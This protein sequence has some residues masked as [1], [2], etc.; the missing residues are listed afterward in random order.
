M[1]MVW[2]HMAAV[3]GTAAD[4]HVCYTFCKKNTFFSFIAVVIIIQLYSTRIVTSG[5]ES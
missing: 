2:Y 5:L 4:R 1:A 3:S